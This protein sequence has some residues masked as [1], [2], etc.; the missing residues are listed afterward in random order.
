[1]S[2]PRSVTAP[3]TEPLR[4]FIVSYLLKGLRLEDLPIALDWAAQHQLHPLSADGTVC[5]ENSCDWDGITGRTK[6]VGGFC[7]SGNSAAKGLRG[8]VR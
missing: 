2:S 1:M 4:I 5:G 7:K 8:V 3:S 6:S